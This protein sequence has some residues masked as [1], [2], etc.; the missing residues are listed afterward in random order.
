MRNTTENDT[1]IQKHY[2]RW[3][4]VIQLFVVI[5]I[6]I[7]LYA[8]TQTNEVGKT[9]KEYIQIAVGILAT[10]AKETPESQA[11]RKWAVD[12]LSNNSP[13]PL[14]EDQKSALESGKVRLKRGV[15][16]FVYG[17][18]NYDSYTPDSD[19]KGESKTNK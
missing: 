17:G 11:I 15:V 10:E 1:F 4:G 5:G 7:G 8:L 13:V 2:K 3:E 18:Y 19:D 14:T 16:N 9:R 12:I 6:T